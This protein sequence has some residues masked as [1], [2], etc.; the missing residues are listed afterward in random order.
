[1]KQ[2]G[3]VGVPGKLGFGAIPLLV[4]PKIPKEMSWRPERRAPMAGAVRLRTRHY[5][6]EARSDSGAE[7]S[8]PLFSTAETKDGSTSL[9]MT[10]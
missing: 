6:R 9:A 7:W 10:V 2:P 4:H 8:H 1:M 5:I 3:G